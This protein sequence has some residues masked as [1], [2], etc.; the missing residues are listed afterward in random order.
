M[1]VKRDNIYKEASVLSGH[2]ILHLFLIILSILK[3]YSRKLHT[4]NN[5]GGK[6]NE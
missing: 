5:S 3:F 1:S 4:S 2:C 6:K